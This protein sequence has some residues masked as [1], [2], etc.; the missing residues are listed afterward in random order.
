MKLLMGLDSE[1][2]RRKLRMLRKKENQMHS[3][4]TKRQLNI[5]VYRRL[6][7]RTSRSQQHIMGVCLPREAMYRT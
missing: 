6:L 1:M 4:N 2:R 5:R 3:Q 7:A